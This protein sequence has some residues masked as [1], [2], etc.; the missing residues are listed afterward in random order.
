MNPRGP[1]VNHLSYA[2]DMVLFTSGDKKSVKMVM[3]VLER[4]QDASGQEINREKTFFLTKE[5][6]DLLTNKQIIVH[7]FGH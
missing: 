4:Y 5:H 7:R 3:N 2:D 1:R 6:S